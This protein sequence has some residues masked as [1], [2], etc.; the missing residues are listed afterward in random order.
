MNRAKL[1]SITVFVLIGLYGVVGFYFLPMANFEGDLTRAGLLPESL[2]G[3]TKPQPLIDKALMQQASWETADVFVVGDSFSVGHVWQT[4]LVR[5]GLKV[6]TETWGS[7]RNIC[8]DFAPWLRERGFRGK[9]VVIEAIERNVQEGF[10]K[11]VECRKMDFHPSSLADRVFWP[12]A[13]SINSNYRNY[14]GRLSIGLRTWFGSLKYKRLSA[15][16]DFKSWKTTDETVVRRVA[17]GCEVFSHPQCQDALF[18]TLDKEKDLG[19]DTLNDLLELN[20]RAAGFN[21][22]W[23]IVPNKSTT[24]IFPEKRFWDQAEPKVKSVNALRVMRQA[25]ANRVVDLYP[26]NNTHLSTTGYL[27]MGDAIYREMQR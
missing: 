24:Y 7:I 6:R 10:R 9:Y 26:G 18:T 27:L 3:W 13:T 2:F 5:H 14:S 21:L 19:A 22:T 8:E 15:S 20:Q 17:Q 1:F 16:P 4:E 12:P 25:L 11:S 23:V